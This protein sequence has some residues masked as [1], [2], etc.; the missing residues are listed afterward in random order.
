MSIG[1]RY[2]NQFQYSLEKDTVILEGS[3][4]VDGY[5][6]VSHY[7]GGGVESVEQT[8]TGTY[9]ITLQDGW[10]YLFECKGQ[11]IRSTLSAVAVTQLKMDPTTI[12][13]DIKTKVP[14]TIVC[15]NYAGSAADPED[16]ASVRFKILVRRSSVSPY[17]TGVTV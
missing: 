11:V 3:F 5:G 6:V 2:L 7:Q 1:S 14:L 12:Q 8:A 10:D 16:D 17:D 15:V 9:D 4:E 13:A